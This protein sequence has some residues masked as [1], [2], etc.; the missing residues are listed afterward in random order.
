MAP[1]CASEA[2]KVLL[3]FFV[4]RYSYSYFLIVRRW[5]AC[6]IKAEKPHPFL[7]P[8]LV[9][10]ARLEE[11]VGPGLELEAAF[12]QFAAHDVEILSGSIVLID[13]WPFTTGRNIN[14]PN[15]YASYTRKV[16]AI[17]AGTYLNWS[18]VVD[19]HT[20]E[21]FSHIVSDQLCIHE[22]VLKSVGLHLL[23]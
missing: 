22:L 1:E 21:H 15:S 18:Y 9:T 16:S 23:R 5:H 11:D 4:G 12:D 3:D 6:K 14:H 19:S 17:T 7:R 8:G 13:L 10:T 20:V 2:G